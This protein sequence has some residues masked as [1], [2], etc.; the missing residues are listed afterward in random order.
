MRAAG[1]YNPLRPCRNAIARAEP[2][3][4]HSRARNYFGMIPLR[5]DRETAR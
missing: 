1:G 4:I 2:M 3:H 5:R